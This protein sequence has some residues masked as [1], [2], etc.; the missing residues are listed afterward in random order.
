M[1][2]TTTKTTPD[3]FTRYQPWQRFAEPGFWVLYYCVQSAINLRIF[4]LEQPKLISA[5]KS[6]EPYV[7]F[8]MSG[9]V[10][11]ALIPA[12]IAFD[13][14]F[15]LHWNML[16]RYLPY[17]L[18]ATIAYSVIHIVAMFTLYRVIYLIMD[19]PFVFPGWWKIF[20]YQYLKD[21]K[22]YL[23]VIVIINLY[24]LLMLRLQGEASLLDAPDNG[25]PVE[26]IEHPER[27]LVK[28]LGKEFLL[29]AAEIERIEAWGNYVNLRVRGH[30]YPLR[31]TMAA[32]ESRINPKRFIRVHRSYIANLDHITQLEPLES[33]DARAIM[34][35]GSQVPVSRRYLDALRKAS[36]S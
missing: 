9:L 20:A 8:W 11:L 5:V 27:F 21:F 35:D 18:L 32:I 34:T 36:A 15:P 26:A 13:R 14:R 28:K 29:P 7:W 12:V 3:L 6:W 1:D 31:S 22:Y 16:R 30:D 4:S 10:L 25:P 23:A 33:G 2:Q 19:R 17:H 24:R